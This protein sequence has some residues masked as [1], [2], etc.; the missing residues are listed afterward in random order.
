MSYLRKNEKS[1]QIYF[2]LNQD[3]KIIFFATNKYVNCMTFEAYLNIKWSD[4][5]LFD[6]FIAYVYLISLM[7]IGLQSHN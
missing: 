1:Y 4:L 7:V 5:S 3:V 2:S 6:W